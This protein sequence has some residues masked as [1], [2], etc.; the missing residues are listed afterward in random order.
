MD[1]K[2]KDTVK[3]IPAFLKLHWAYVTYILGAIFVIV[4][5]VFFYTL[6]VYRSWQPTE[7]A[8]FFGIMGNLFFGAGMMMILKGVL[9]RDRKSVV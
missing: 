8:V 4:G 1:T 7:E 5:V 6:I 3:K 9:K 2:W